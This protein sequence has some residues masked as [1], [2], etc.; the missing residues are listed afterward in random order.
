M[1]KQPPR[2][3]NPL[4]ARNK[5]TK[6]FFQKTTFLESSDT[7]ESPLRNPGACLGESSL[8]AKQV[9]HS[10]QRCQ[11][12]R[13]VRI[14]CHHGRCKTSKA[15]YDDTTNQRIDQNWQCAKLGQRGLD[16]RSILVQCPAALGTA[17][18]DGQILVCNPESQE[19]IGF[20]KNHLLQQSTLKWVK[21]HQNF[22]SI[23]R[24]T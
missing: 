20:Q 16:Y 23:G 15:H 17:S 22:P 11:L 24:D 6:S 7:H 12:F 13:T 21:N 10:S 18:L 19:P 2:K 3:R 4:V 14:L 8:Q 9:L 5:T 1:S